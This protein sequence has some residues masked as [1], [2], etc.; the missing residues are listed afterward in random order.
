MIWLQ[1]L[2]LNRVLWGIDF[3]KKS[4]FNY[5]SYTLNYDVDI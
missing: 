5:F 3:R 2:F 1:E 4:A